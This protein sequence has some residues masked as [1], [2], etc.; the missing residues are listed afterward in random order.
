M[1]FYTLLPHEYFLVSPRTL[2][3]RIV[4]KLFL[5]NLSEHRNFNIFRNKPCL[6]KVNTMSCQKFV[7]SMCRLSNTWTFSSSS[8]LKIISTSP[9]G[10]AEFH[11]NPALHQTFGI[12]TNDICLNAFNRF[13]SGSINL[14]FNC[15]PR[16]IKI[17]ICFNTYNNLQFTYSSI[18]ASL[19][20]RRA[21]WFIKKSP[22]RQMHKCC[23]YTC[24]PRQKE[25][26]HRYF[27]VMILWS[28]SIWKNDDE[29]FFNLFIFTKITHKCIKIYFSYPKCG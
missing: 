3:T 12:V 11:S 9:D 10:L 20:S 1:L 21:F 6:F 15:L 17:N 27:F 13:S 7:N 4:K 5:H 25:W 26:C 24:F 16:A 14:Q 22:A 29:S 18:K 8:R 23:K 19:F 28:H 2:I